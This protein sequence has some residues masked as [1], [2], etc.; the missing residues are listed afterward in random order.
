MDIP[1]V[2]FQKLSDSLSY[3]GLGGQIIS[4]MDPHPESSTPSP[5]DSSTQRRIPRTTNL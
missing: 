2:E 5:D 4:I 1:R 3:P